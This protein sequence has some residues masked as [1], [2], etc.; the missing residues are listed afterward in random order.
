MSIMVCPNCRM[1]VLSRS[2]G[3]CP[4][5]HFVIAEAEEQ[6][7]AQTSKISPTISPETSLK[8]EMEKQLRP[9]RRGLILIGVAQ[10]MVAQRFSAWGALLIV[11]GLASYYFREAPMF[12]VYAVPLAWVGL[13]NLLQ[14]ETLLWKGYALLQGYG[15][16]ILYQRFRRFRQVEQVASSPH[17]PHG[18]LSRSARLF[19]WLAITLGVGALAAFVIAL[20]GIRANVFFWHSRTLLTILR[21][22]E[23]LAVNSGILALAT[24]LA[25]LVAGH[26]RR[27]ASIVGCVAGALPMTTEVGV[28]LLFNS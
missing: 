15:A 17:D 21:S 20:V 14:G 25:A 28:H 16:Y 19:P 7:L 24:G 4:S 11:V 12:V 26:P 18:A 13:S 8:S 22:L 9:W 3:T 6:P 1:R 27:W 2:D 5:C 10:M 23:P